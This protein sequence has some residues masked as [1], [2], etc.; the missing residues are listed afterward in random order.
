MDSQNLTSGILFLDLTTA[1]HRLIREWTSGINMSATLER[2][3]AV[4]EAEGIAI[5]E[6][7]ERIQQPCLLEE[8]GA[9]PFLIQLMKDVH[10]STWMTLGRAQKVATTKRGTRPGSPLANCIFHVSMS[11]ILHHLQAWIDTQPAYNAILQELDLPGS[12]V[13]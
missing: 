2:V 4:L 11:N 3:F 5:D 1:F 6:M 9:P 12:F 8:L 13:A 7:C 10:S